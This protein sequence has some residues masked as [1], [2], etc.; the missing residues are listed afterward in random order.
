[1]EMGENGGSRGGLGM[2]VVYSG[3]VSYSFWR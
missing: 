3:N 2:V 1:M